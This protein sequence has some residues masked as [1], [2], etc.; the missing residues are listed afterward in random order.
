MS[1]LSCWRTDLF[2]LLTALNPQEICNW[3]LDLAFGVGFADISVSRA[4]PSICQL[5]FTRAKRFVGEGM[6][7]AVDF[8]KYAK[9]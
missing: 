2:N 3:Q 7:A 8:G 4:N 1:S 9:L 5:N 6:G